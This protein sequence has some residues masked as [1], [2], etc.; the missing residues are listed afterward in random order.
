MKNERLPGHNKGN[1]PERVE[2]KRKA[3]VEKDAGGNENNRRRPPEHVKRRRKAETEKHGGGYRNN[4][5]RL[6]EHVKRRRKAE[7]EKH[8][9]GYRDNR[10][11]LPDYIEKEVNKNRLEIDSWLSGNCIQHWSFWTRISHLKRNCPLKMTGVSQCRT[12]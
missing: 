9:G 8:G 12:Q 11:R 5:R 1:L 7:T 10:R 2:R 6:P 3:E 4:R